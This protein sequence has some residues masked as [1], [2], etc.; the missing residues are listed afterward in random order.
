MLERKIRGWDRMTLD[1]VRA[2]TKDATT[3]SAWS[4]N[5]ALEHPMLVRSDRLA[6][7]QLRFIFDDGVELS[8]DFLDDRHLRWTT[9]D[10]MSA[11][12]IYNASPAP[13]YDDVMIF[14]HYRS[15]F[16]L[17]HCMNI[18]FDFE[19]GYAAAIDSQLGN[20]I[21]PREVINTVRIGHIDGI[22]APADAMKPHF[23]SELNGKAV[24]WGHPVGSVPSVPGRAPGRGIKYIFPSQ[25]YLTYCMYFRTNECWM[26]TIPCDYLKIKENLYFIT[27]IEARQAGFQLNMLMNLDCMLDVQTGFGI[28]GTSDEPLR[29]EVWMRSNRAGTFVDPATDLSE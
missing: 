13:G 21:S 17:P 3:L 15:G 8:Y 26:A 29:L 7:K 10:G 1:E 22:A 12:E 11:E 14:H 9:P 18:V 25:K 27:A 24:T 5:N 20:P 19:T 2:F 28:G 4:W 23:T 6:G 16:D